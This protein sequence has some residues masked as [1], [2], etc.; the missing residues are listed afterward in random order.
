[1]LEGNELEQGWL[2]IVRQQ[3]L[4]EFLMQFPRP[5]ASMTERADSLVALL[6][7]HMVRPSGSPAGSGRRGEA[8]A[9]YAAG[10]PDEFLG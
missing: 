10:V 1:M 9:A 3:P 7:E 5:D 8:M 6:R 4:R 2:E